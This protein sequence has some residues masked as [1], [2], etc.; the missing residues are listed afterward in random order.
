MRAHG[1]AR[2]SN[3][4]RRRLTY[5]ANQ[6]VPPTRVAVTMQR[7]TEWRA[8]AMTGRNEASEGGVGCAIGD[9]DNDG[10]FDIFAATTGTTRFIAKHR[11]HS[12]AQDARRGGENHAVSE[13]GATMTHGASICR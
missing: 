8:S 3:G 11:G 5:I 6:S 10:D 13:T 9:Y 4:Y 1:G 7:V 2:G 12:Q